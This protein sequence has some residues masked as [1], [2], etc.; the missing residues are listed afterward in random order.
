MTPSSIIINSNHS[1]SNTN[2]TATTA[3]TRI[4]A[5]VRMWVLP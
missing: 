3:T 2:I 5:A 4:K 1:S